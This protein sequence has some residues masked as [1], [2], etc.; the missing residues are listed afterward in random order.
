VIVKHIDGKCNITDL[1]TKEIKDAIHFQ[2]MAFTITTPRRIADM[3]PA[4]CTDYI[5]IEGGV[6]MDDTRTNSSWI[7]KLVREAFS[8]MKRLP[9][10]ILGTHLL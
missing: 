7:P 9:T 5:A 8:H 1:F 2:K 3:S 4:T 6:G 10:N